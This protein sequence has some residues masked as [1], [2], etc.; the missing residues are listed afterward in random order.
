M[1]SRNEEP[2]LVFKDDLPLLN[3]TEST[4][5]SILKK[6]TLRVPKSEATS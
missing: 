6:V 3:A 5:I 4:A 1:D 2:E